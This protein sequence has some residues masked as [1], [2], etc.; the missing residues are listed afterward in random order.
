[1]VALG[2]G[3]GRAITYIG[4][5]GGNGSS[6]GFEEIIQKGDLIKCDNPK[7]ESSFAR[8]TQ[9]ESSFVGLCLAR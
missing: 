1:M 6:K 2:V 5:A 4:Q 9:I 7:T 3:A 8:Q